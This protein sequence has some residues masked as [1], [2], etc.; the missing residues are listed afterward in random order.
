MNPG[1]LPQVPI[2]PAGKEPL[3]AGFTEA[4]REALMQSRRWESYMAMGMESCVV[5]TV[6]AG[7]AGTFL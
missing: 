6:L 4:D 7:G 5:K 2:Y 1:S 3:P